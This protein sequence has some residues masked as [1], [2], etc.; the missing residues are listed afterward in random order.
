M[1]NNIQTRRY[2]RRKCIVFRKTKEAFGG[3]SNMASG[4]PINANNIII[5]TSEALYQ[6]CRFPYSADIQ[7]LIIQQKSPMT[8]KMKSKPFRSQTRNDWDNVKVKIMRWCLR[9][10]LACNLQKFGGLLLE[11]GDKPIV[12]DSHKDKFWGAAEQKDGLIEGMN[13][14]GRLLMELREELKANGS[15][16]LKIVS[17]PQITDFFLLGKPITIVNE[18]YAPFAPKK[19]KKQKYTQL[20]QQ[21]IF[22]N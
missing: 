22:L 19:V 10:K 18:T 17:S 3:L 2:D 7:K 11:T 15:E 5:R 21:S 12:E 13:V 20:A 6:A 16:S 9:A 14:L 1:T 8:A 4:Y